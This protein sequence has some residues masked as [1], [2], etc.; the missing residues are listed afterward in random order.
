ME[1]HSQDREQ[2][3]VNADLFSGWWKEAR[4]SLR[5]WWGKLTDDDIEYIAGQKD[6]LIGLVQ[7]RYGYAREKAREEVERRIQETQSQ[8][9]NSLTKVQRAIGDAADSTTQQVGE[10][11][12]TLADNLREKAPASGVLASAA[13]SVADQMEATGLY[14]QKSDMTQMTQDITS[15]IRRYPLHSLLIGV[16]FGYLLA[17]RG[18]R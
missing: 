17:R 18:E 5:S 3:R 14:L 16:G 7:Q 10:Q 15:L 12:Q 1:S 6:R 2:E 8:V 13:T 11:M 4:G 9:G